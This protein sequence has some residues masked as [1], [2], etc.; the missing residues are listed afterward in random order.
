MTQSSMKNKKNTDHLLIFLC[1]IG[2][3]TKSIFSRSFA[4]LSIKCMITELKK[5][6]QVYSLLLKDGMFPERILSLERHSFLKKNK[7]KKKV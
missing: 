2:L 6:M 7:I 3:K 1:K 5:T 4:I